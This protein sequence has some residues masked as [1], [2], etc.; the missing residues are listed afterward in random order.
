MFTNAKSGIE[1]EFLA[2]NNSEY[3]KGLHMKTRTI[4]LVPLVVAMFGC[5]ADDDSKDPTERMLSLD[6]LE[7]AIPVAAQGTDTSLTGL[8]LVQFTSRL[9]I[10][11][12]TEND[13]AGEL[14]YLHGRQATLI[15][16]TESGFKTSFC[17]SYAFHGDIN[18]SRVPGADG[19]SYS[20]GLVTDTTHFNL[21]ISD[22]LEI[23][24]ELM[25][26]V[27]DDAVGEYQLL[28]VKL[29]DATTFAD[30]SSELDISANLIL[31]GEQYEFSELGGI[32]TCIGSGAGGAKDY[33]N[34]QETTAYH[35][36]LSTT[37]GASTAVSFALSEL[38]CPL[39]IN[40]NGEEVSAAACDGINAAEIKESP[41]D[42]SEVILDTRFRV[43]AE[44]NP[45]R[46]FEFNARIG[47]PEA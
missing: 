10:D 47:L 39:G 16:E 28:G 1:I 2:L 27:D 21:N 11:S 43:E 26:Q 4:A 19:T 38:E 34:D 14:H 35:S 41:F 23:E 7:E 36:G 44:D 3:A 17:G 22:N 40:N 20:A 29:S 6:E 9:S 5:G 45:Q 32:L 25:I 46:V 12:S 8:W 13:E 42:D 31:E 18:F 37:G 15:T 30:A 24:G 33:E